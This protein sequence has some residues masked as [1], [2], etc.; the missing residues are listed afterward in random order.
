MSEPIQHRGELNEA[1]EGDGEFIVSCADPSKA[2]DA[3]EEVFDFV[4]TAVVAAM[5]CHARA[6]RTFGR[7]ANTCA[8]LAKPG[9]KR[10][11]I[12]AFVADGAPAPQRRQEW[13]DGVQ[14]V[15]LAS[16]QGD[17]HSPAATLHDGRELGIE[18]AFG[19]THRLRSLA[20]TRIGAVLVQFDVRAV[21]A[22]QAAHCAACDQGE[23]L[24]EEADGAPA[25]EP[26]IDR[27]PRAETFRQI[28][29]WDSRAQHVENRGEHESIVFRRPAPTSH[30]ANLPSA[31][32]GARP[33]NFFSRPQS[34]SGNCVRSIGFMRPLRSSF[35]PGVPTF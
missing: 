32:L 26:R 17:R 28:A 21:N 2:F 22:A 7:D 33:V 35:F 4:P 34:G 14:V 27:T 23:D 12:E 19:T 20:A 13:V 15:A 5:K 8:L 1:E 25:P 24:R 29:P 6:S 16:G 31:H 11:G 3:A 18:A 30:C 10:V 9:A